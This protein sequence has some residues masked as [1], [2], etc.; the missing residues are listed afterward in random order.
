MAA[1][2]GFVSGAAHLAGFLDM[3]QAE[4]G[5]S[6]HTIDAYRRDID[7]FLGFA[8]THALALGD[9]ER[10]HI[11]AYFEAQARDGLAAAS[12]ARRLSALKQFSKF[13]VASEVIDD[14]AFELV[15]GPKQA[16][17]LPKVL[18]IADVDRLLTAAAKRAETASG[19]DGLRA[20][21]LLALVEVLYATGL[22]ASELVALPRSV[23]T[24]DGKILT[25]KGKGRRERLV[26]LTGAAMA[27]LARFQA[28]TGRDAADNLATGASDYYLFPS[29]GAE[30]HLTRQRLG[31]EMKDLAEAAGLDPDRVS[32]HVL[33]HAFA[34]HLL[35][36]GADLRVVQQLLGHADISTTQIYTHVLQERLKQLV[37]QH[38]PLS[39]ER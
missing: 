18:S 4:R 31:Q 13:L 34:S 35:D 36:R 5:A 9:I 30:G 7:D 24:G 23:L 28:A 14:D 15:R 38:H 27:A 29:R 32:P 1:R 3:L 8:A 33:R 10:R 11:A 39:K 19:P 17:A 26:P 22:R 12:R 6:Q 37:F 2:F 21:R 25:I 16:R 20:L